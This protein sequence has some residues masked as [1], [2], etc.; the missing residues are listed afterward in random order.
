[1]SA[2][3]FKD[4]VVVLTGASSGMGEAMALQ[5]A[6]Q[7]ARL[8]LASI[9]AEPLAAVA[10][11]C[12]QRGAAAID[13]MTD[14]GDEAQCARLMERAMA[15][16]G[17]INVLVNNAGITMWARFD[18]L[19]SLRPIEQVM[20]VNYFGSVY[21][22]YYALPHLKATAGRIIAISSVSAKTG[23]PMRT[24]YAAS[25]GAV[26]SFFDALRIELEP[27]AVTVTQVFPNFVATASHR[28]AFGADGK[29]LGET[30][31]QEGSIMTAEEAARII[32]DAGAK[33]KRE[34]IMTLK[35][36]AAPWLKLI[37]PRVV[38]RAA[39][40]AIQSGR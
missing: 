33:R 21:C 36:K 10:E 18:E 34:Q 13:V 26:A 40:R 9:D 28:Q 1:M 16:F 22:T 32:L 38:D 39:A 24:G 37:A 27:H 8:V 35:G 20:R 11:T 15:E 12:R 6:D 3:P 25:K 29:P 23:V 2:A 4:H 5:L 14:V 17:R 7:G 31:L 19:V 30:P